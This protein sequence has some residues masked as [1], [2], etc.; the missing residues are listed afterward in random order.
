MLPL[1]VFAGDGNEHTLREAVPHLADQFGL[2]EAERNELL[3]SGQTIIYNRV[4]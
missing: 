1:L 2:T 3:A 4:A